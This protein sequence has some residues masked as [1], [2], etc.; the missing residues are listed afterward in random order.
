MFGKE[1][2]KASPSLPLTNCLAKTYVADTG[3]KKAGRQVLNHCQIVGEVACE[4]LKRLPDWL[5]ADL[6]P[7]GVELI[8]AAHDIGKVSPTFQAKIYGG[9]DAYKN[10]LPSVLKSFNPEIERQWGGHAGVSQAAAKHVKAGKFIPEILGQHHGYSPNVTNL[11]TDD[12]FGGNPWQ[13]RREEL[14]AELKI[15]LQTDFPTVSNELQARVLAGFT[16][17]SDWI[18]SGS[19]FNEPE[20]NWQPKIQKAVNDAGFVRPVYKPDLSFADVFTWSPRDTQQRF[21]EQVNQPGVYVLEAPMGLGKTEAALYAAYQLLESNQATGFYFALPTQLT[22]DKIH[23][24]VGD[25]LN[26]ILDGDS[27][28]QQP[29]LLHGNA[30]LKTELGKEGNPGGSWFQASKR[31]ILAPFAVGTIDQALMAVMNV[32]HGFVRTF[33]LAGK[34]VILDE[35]HSYDSYTGTLLD[36]L[37]KALRDLHCT[38]IIL[39]ATL[40]KQ[41][42][43]SLLGSMSSN[44]DYPLISAAPKNG[45]LIEQ[46]VQKITDINVKIRHCHGDGEAIEE[47]LRRAEQGQQ[48]L[49]IENTVA[50]AQQIYRLLSARDCTPKIEC[51]LLHS[52][53]LKIDREQNDN[54]WTAIYGKDGG[55][56]R[57][58]CGRI[59]VGTQVLEQ[60]LDIDADFLVS[61]FAPSDMLLQRLGRLWRHRETVRAAG[62]KCEAWLLSPVLPNAI[63]NPEQTFGKTAKVYSP[64]VLCRSLEVWQSLPAV[65]VPGQIRE[66]IEATYARREEDGAMLGHFNALEKKREEMQRQAL[67]GL[68]KAG[69][70]LPEEKASTRY[71]EQDSVEVLLIKNYRIDPEQDGVVVGFLNDDKSILLPNKGKGLSPQQR[72]ELAATLLQ[73]TVRVAEYLAPKAPPGNMLDWLQDYLY[74]GKHEGESRLRVVKVLDSG[75]VVSLDGGEAAE[76][77]TLQYDQYF[78]YQA[79]K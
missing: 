78:G 76:R 15:A 79:E 4:L 39:S 21:I 44:G 13:Q 37:V 50:K 28:H 66:I 19:L 47:A 70:T 72:R 30:W 14:L 60:S 61:R 68:S 57:Q 67:F 46:R 48:V 65:A 69:K 5:V 49:W 63:E 16:S 52:R 26:K 23:Y 38:V 64:Y 34:V 55:E 25:F 51:G 41:R 31:G 29:L 71:S 27:P 17:V 24:R 18:G 74:L 35:V 11:A 58:Q 75:V 40:T 36:E 54:R 8:A 32:K 77:Y 12:V 62:A 56:D 6:F 59:L 33:G 2:T 3:E 1:T 20:E 73:N 53:F 42:R 45:G 10:N 43:S 7:N 9:T 22:S